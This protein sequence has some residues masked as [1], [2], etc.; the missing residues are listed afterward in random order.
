MPPPAV[1]ASAGHLEDLSGV[2]VKVS[3]SSVA[4]SLSI[5][6]VCVVFARFSSNAR[7][8]LQ[9]CACT[10]GFLVVGRRVL[11]RAASRVGHVGPNSVYFFRGK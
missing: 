2:K 7:T 1:P 6:I 4:K 8:F 9:E 10:Q 3:E 5:E 11:A